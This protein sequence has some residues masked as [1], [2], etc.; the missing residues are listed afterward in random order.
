[1]SEA[2]T[3]EL[4]IYGFGYAPKGWAM[5]NGQTLSV[6]QNQ[7]LFSLLGVMYGGDGVN[8]FNLPNLQ[9]M[10]PLHFGQ[11]QGGMNYSQGMVAGVSTVSLSASQMPQHNHGMVAGTGGNTNT[12]VSNL[13]GT[14]SGIYSYG[15]SPNAQLVDGACP[16]DGNSQP[17]DNM[18]PYLVLNI[19]ICLAG[20]YPSRS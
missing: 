19:C 9:G 13:P 11:L 2:Y 18:Q 3:G 14:L 6:Q 8:T 7:A 4:R 17:H 12:P 20:L 10:V 16:P 5:C 1:M 15:T